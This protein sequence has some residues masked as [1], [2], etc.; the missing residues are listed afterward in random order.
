MM[1]I[2]CKGLKVKTSLSVI[3]Q[4][5]TQ[6]H[7]PVLSVANQSSECAGF[8]LRDSHLHTL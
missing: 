5:L 7:T 3:F 1:F 6:V 8:L 2:S 4:M